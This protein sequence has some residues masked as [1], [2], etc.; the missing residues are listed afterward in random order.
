MRRKALR[1]AS[2]RLIGTF[3]IGLPIALA[4]FP[5]VGDIY[6]RQSASRDIEPAAGYMYIGEQPATNCPKAAFVQSKRNEKVGNCNDLK[7]LSGRFAALLFFRCIKNEKKK[8]RIKW[9]ICSCKRNTSLYAEKKLKYS[10]VNDTGRQSMIRWREQSEKFRQYARILGLNFAEIGAPA[11]HIKHLKESKW[12]LPIHLKFHC[13][14]WRHPAARWVPL[15]SE[16][17][18]LEYT[19]RFTGTLADDVGCLDPSQKCFKLQVQRSWQT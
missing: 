18:I 10:S 16:K 2:Q 14:R 8:Y 12:G 1:C 3:A 7:I 19:Y 4:G 11:W 15:K 17:E 6:T 9:N 5:R 13:H